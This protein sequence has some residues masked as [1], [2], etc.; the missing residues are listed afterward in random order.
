MSSFRTKNYSSLSKITKLVIYVLIV[1]VVVELIVITSDYSEIRLMNSVLNNELEY[2]EKL[3]QI[4]INDYRVSIIGT[5]EFPLLILSSI[6]FFYWFYRAY[7]NLESLG[8]LGLTFNPKWVVGYFFIPFLCLWKP[9]EALKEIWKVSDP[10]NTSEDYMW[11]SAKVSRVLAFWWITFVLSNMTGTLLLTGAFRTETLED[12]IRL[13]MYD[14]AASIAIMISDAIL[15]Y[16]M[17]K[18]SSRQEM[19]NSNLSLIA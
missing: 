4:E 19:K 16:I 5:I 10:Y 13:D 14:I 17:K 12:W 18:I 3:S 2:S 15:I 9:Y 6:L 8:A 7:R 11:R 1:E